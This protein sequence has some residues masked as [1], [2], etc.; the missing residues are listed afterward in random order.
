MFSYDYVF[1]LSIS[2]TMYYFFSLHV[3]PS[4]YPAKQPSLTHQSFSGLSP[5]SAQY[6]ELICNTGCTAHAF[7][8][9]NWWKCGK[10]KWSQHQ[11]SGRLYFWL[12]CHK[13]WP[14]SPILLLVTLNWFSSHEKDISSNSILGSSINPYQ[15]IFILVLFRH[16]F[17]HLQALWT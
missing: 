2:W 12:Y 11:F 9:H 3:S 16:Y 1:F 13:K 10:F 4:F 17:S 14:L 8:T 15:G 5:L 6:C 7:S